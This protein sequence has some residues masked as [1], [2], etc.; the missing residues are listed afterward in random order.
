MFWKQTKNSDLKNDVVKQKHGSMDCFSPQKWEVN[1]CYMWTG[2]SVFG[3]TDIQP[4]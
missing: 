2:Y 1:A 4:C 3:F